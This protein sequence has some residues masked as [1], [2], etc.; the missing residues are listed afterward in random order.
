MLIIYIISAVLLL[1]AVLGFFINNLSLKP[2]VLTYDEISLEVEK[3]Y[4]KAAFFKHYPFE[5][6]NVKSAYGYNLSA[7]WLPCSGSKKAVIFSH[8][9][10]VNMAASLRFLDVF[11]DKGYNVFLYDQRYHASSGG[12]NCTLG[13]YEK[14]DLQTCVSWVCEKL[15]DGAVVGVHGES[16]GASCSI[17]AAAEDKRIAFIVADCPYSD[18]YDEARYQLIFRYGKIAT[19]FLF[20][21]NIMNYLRVGHG[22]KA[23][24]PIKVINNCNAPILFIHGKADTFTPHES[25][26]KMHKTYTGPKQIYI[27]DGAEHGQSVHVNRQKYREVVHKFIDEVL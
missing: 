13:F 10:S 12:K 7:K 15:G 23:I 21:A 14:D 17:L 4:G 9:F 1:L 11:Y 3:T 20:L 26:I 22:Y 25:S 18:L 24:S 5:N 8:G 6:V 16:M 19:F 2:R 27:A